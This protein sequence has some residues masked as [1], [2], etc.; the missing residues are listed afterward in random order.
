MLCNFNHDS[1]ANMMMSLACAMQM[2]YEHDDVMSTSC[3]CEGN[4]DDIM[5]T[6]CSY[7]ANTNNI[8]PC[9]S[10]VA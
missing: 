2:Q 1:H 6:W 10:Y 3:Q 9:Q 4:H 7:D 5:S 8:M